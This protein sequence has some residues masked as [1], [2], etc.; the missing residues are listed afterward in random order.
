MSGVDTIQLEGFALADEAAALA[1]VTDVGGV[2]TFSAEGTTI[3][4]A[5][6][7]TDDLNANDFFLL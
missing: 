3:T 4:F 5:G 6:L 1:K 2:A 7:T